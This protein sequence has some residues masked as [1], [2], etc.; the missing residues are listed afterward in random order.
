MWLNKT[1]PVNFFVKY[2]TEAHHGPPSIKHMMTPLPFKVHNGSLES[3]DDPSYLNL[4]A[5][6]DPSFMKVHDGPS[7]LKNYGGQE[8]IIDISNPMHVNI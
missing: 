6:D 2:K 5:H 8:I 4:N 3:Q 7:S 1:A